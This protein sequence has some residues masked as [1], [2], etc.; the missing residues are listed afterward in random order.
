[1][2]DVC[3]VNKMDSATREGID[4]VLSS[5]HESNADARIVLAASPFHVEGD[6]EE[7]RGSACSPSRTAQP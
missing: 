4:A 1:M 3:V 2:A 7:I 6:A 5:I